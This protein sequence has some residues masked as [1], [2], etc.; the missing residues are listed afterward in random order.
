MLARKQPAIPQS[1]LMD[2]SLQEHI[3]TFTHF[4]PLLLCKDSN[5][6]T[7]MNANLFLHLVDLLSPLPFFHSFNERS[8]KRKGSI[9]LNIKTKHTIQTHTIV[10][11]MSIRPLADWLTS[12]A[13]GGA[14]VAEMHLFIYVSW[15]L[16]L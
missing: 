4:H 10:I 6:W 5:L 2:C 15:I 12:T 8:S 7:C 13:R 11:R 1:E 3:V 9:A 14:S 16:C